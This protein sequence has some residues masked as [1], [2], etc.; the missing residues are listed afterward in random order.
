MRAI[1]EMLP[2]L[3]AEAVA[4]DGEACAV[5]GILAP[6]WRERWGDGIHNPDCAVEQEGVA[7]AAGDADG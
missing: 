6:D 7:D 5:L 4:G 2:R 3:V 1:G